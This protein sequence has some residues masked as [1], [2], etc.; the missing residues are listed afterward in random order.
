MFHFSPTFKFDAER[1]EYVAELNG[2]AFVCDKPQESYKKEAK[3]LSKLYFEKL[4]EMI[5]FMLPELQEIYGEIDKEKLPQLLGKPTVNLSTFQ[6]MY[7]EQRL[8]DIHIIEFEYG[9]DFEEFFYFN[10]DG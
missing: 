4:P 2:V 9:D 8:D 7:P 10:I 3:K 1:D 5:E 6:I